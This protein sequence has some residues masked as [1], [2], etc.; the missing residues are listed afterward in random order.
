MPV[1]LALSEPHAAFDVGKMMVHQLLRF[2]QVL[3]FQRGHDQAMVIGAAVILVGTAL[4]MGIV[5]R[6]RPAVQQA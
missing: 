2:R 5:P 4:A 1:A 6:P 3:G